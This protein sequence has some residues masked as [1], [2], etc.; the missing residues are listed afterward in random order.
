MRSLLLGSAALVL[1]AASGCAATAE[2]PDLLCEGKE[3]TERV[4]TSDH[5]LVLESFE[6][7]TRNRP[8]TL[9]VVLHGDSPS[10]R[11]TYQYEVARRIAERHANVVAVGMLRPG[12]QDRTGA[13]SSGQ[14]GRATGDNYTAA[15]ADAIA[16]A[17][18]L[19]AEHHATERLVVVGHSGGAAIATLAASRHHGIVD[20]LVL[21]GC[22]CDLPAWREHMYRVRRSE[23]WKA[24]V[25]SLSPLDLAADFDPEASALVVVGSEDRIAPPELSERYVAALLA[26]GNSAELVLLAGKQ[27]DILFDA[28]V[29]A[30]IDR[31][32]QDSGM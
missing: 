17:L 6:S 28:E 2:R 5:C 27:H 21:V 14:R 19:L 18:R 20:H 9:V 1:L 3:L 8:G 29:D 30:I 13:G 23:L 15:N 24:P 10:A 26:H 32:A 12:Y 25:E 16:E 31:V 22:P 4:R 7:S 11:P